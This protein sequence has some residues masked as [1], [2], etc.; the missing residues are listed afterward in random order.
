[1]NLKYYLLKVMD[2][3]SLF[4]I[5]NIDCLERYNVDESRGFNCVYTSDGYKSIKDIILKEKKFTCKDLIDK[6][7]SNIEANLSG[8]F[9]TVKCSDNV[10]GII[11]LEHAGFKQRDRSNYYV[12]DSIPEI[13]ISYID[14]GEKLL[15]S[16][17]IFKDK[18]YADLVGQEEYIGILKTYLEN[19]LILHCNNYPIS[20][21]FKINFEFKFPDTEL[22]DYC[23]N[24][25]NY[26]F[27]HCRKLKDNLQ[28]DCFLDVIDGIINPTYSRLYGHSISLNSAVFSSS[29]NSFIYKV[30]AKR[31]SC[32]EWI[33]MA[34]DNDYYDIDGDLVHKSFVGYCSKDE[35]RY[36]LKDL[37]K[38]GGKF[39]HKRYYV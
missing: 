27:N 24:G 12:F 1:M 26:L 10:S 33:D 35:R 29:Q 34:Y 37:Y 4:A 2:S 5:G 16:C 20:L 30:N 21:D 38:E 19:K 23:N 8:N 15:A 9:I 13:T 6:L 28:I 17:F 31:T 14:D 7:Y 22:F 3:K 36:L 18:Y 25:G 11:G 39:Y 32:G